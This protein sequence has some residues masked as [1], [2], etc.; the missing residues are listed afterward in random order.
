M[1]N[2]LK[3]KGKNIVHL[4]QVGVDSGQVLITDPCYIDSQWK[5]EEYKGKRILKHKKTKEEF[6]YPDHFDNYEQTLAQAGLKKTKLEKRTPR[7]VITEKTREDYK[8]TI[9]ELVQEGT[10]KEM[11]RKKSGTYS[12]NGCC[13]ATLGELNEGGGQLN[14]EMGHAGA[15]VASQT[16]HGDGSYNVWGILD[17]DGCIK[18]IVVDFGHE[19][20]GD[21]IGE[22]YANQHKA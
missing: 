13:E 8:K 19:E 18:Q 16:R 7:K 6:I 11:P 20:D 3:L 15:G 21:D 2:I 10:L 9:N 17:D 14:H 12:Y 1:K 22:Q 4:G 5:K